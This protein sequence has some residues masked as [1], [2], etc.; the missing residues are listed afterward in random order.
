MNK[1]AERAAK[2]KFAHLNRPSA[3][4]RAVTTNGIS[5]KI[6][7]SSEFNGNNQIWELPY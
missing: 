2:V 1:G 4:T 6:N 3:G 5:R 7:I